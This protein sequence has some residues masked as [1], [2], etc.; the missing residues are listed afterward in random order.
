MT[1]SR[2]AHPHEFAHTAQDYRAVTEVPGILLNHDQVGRFAHRYLYGAEMGRG[3]RVLE[4]ACGAGSGAGLVRAGAAAYV[5][6]DYTATVLQEMCRDYGPGMP[7]AQ[8]DAQDLP[9]ADGVFELVLC[10]EAIYY[11]DDYRAFLEECRRVLGE[12]GRVLIV[13]G[14]PEWVDFVPG[15]LSHYYPPAAELA[16]S[17]GEA[18]FGAVQLWGAL[19]TTAATPRQALVNHVRHVLLRPARAAVAPLL[20]TRVGQQAVALLKRVL[21]GELVP[22]PPILGVQEAR[23][24]AEGFVL[25]EL[26]PA[27]VDRIH[28]VHYVCAEKSKE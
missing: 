6:L 20:T 27:R 28:R 4:V 7:L 11:L 22:L 25:T 26:D 1:T 24:Y 13:Q 5:G 17:L 18:G 15:S 10:Y 8:G 14:N 21:Y 9:F 3:V 19:P 12:R 16:A 2:P 23:R